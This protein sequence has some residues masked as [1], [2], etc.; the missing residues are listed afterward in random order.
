VVGRARE[1]SP[2]WLAEAAKTRARGRPAGFNLKVEEAHERRQLFISECGDMYRIDGWLELERRRSSSKSAIESPSPLAGADARGC[3]SGGAP[4]LT[5]L[6]HHVPWTQAGCRCATV[7][8][9]MSLSTPPS[10]GLKGELGGATSQSWH[11]GSD[12]EQDVQRLACD[13]VLHR[14]LKGG[15]HGGRRRPSQADGAAYAVASPQ[16]AAPDLRRGRDATGY[17]RLDASP[18]SNCGKGGRTDL[19]KMIP[20]AI[21]TTGW[22]EGGWR[23]VSGLANQ[24]SS[25]LPT[26]R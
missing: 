1:W 13:G 8:G 4:T 26:G 7:R 23:V 12:L 5:E 17:G 19:G 2:R 6:A 10:K 24:L 3:P 9:R 22:S 20:S 11:A 14:V 18:S 15:L 25:S 21:T 16:G